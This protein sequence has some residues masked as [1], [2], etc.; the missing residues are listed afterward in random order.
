M[1]PDIE[2]TALEARDLEETERIH[3]QEMKSV[4]KI[5]TL[6]HLKQPKTD[7][8]AIEHPGHNTNLGEATMHASSLIISLVQEAAALAP[9]AELKQAAAVTLIIFENIQVGDLIDLWL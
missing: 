9:F 7:Q 3:E 1:E 2:I 6:E 5:S 8:H 4:K